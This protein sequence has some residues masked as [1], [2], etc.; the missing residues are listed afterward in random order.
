MDSRDA[1][2]YFGGNGDHI[3]C[4][5]DRDNP[6]YV[7]TGLAASDKADKST[8]R[9]LEQAA[10]NAGEWAVKVA[11]KKPHHNLR[12][13]YVWKGGG[14]VKIP[15]YIRNFSYGFIVI[16]HQVI[17]ATPV[18]FSGKDATAFIGRLEAAAREAVPY[19]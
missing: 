19:A 12:V 5:M 9:E 18:I 14:V 15:Y 7:V 16:D 13:P 8:L 2:F 10:F 17:T 1:K 4:S 11:N 3:K 6:V